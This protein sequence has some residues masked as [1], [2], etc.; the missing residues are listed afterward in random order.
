MSVDP[1]EPPVL[2]ALRIALESDHSAYASRPSQLRSRLNRILG[3]EATTH[4]REVHLVVTALDENVP[5]ELRAAAPLSRADLD[6]HSE[7]LAAA[8]GWT[9][10]A[11]A[12]AVG[13]WVSALGLA[14]SDADSWA[15]PAARRPGTAAA[16]SWR[17]SPS[18]SGSLEPGT[19]SPDDG[20]GRSLEGGQTAGTRDPEA[21]S[22]V[23]PRRRDDPMATDL[24]DAS[25]VV[26]SV[27]LPAPESGRRE[28]AP[29]PWPSSSRF[30]VVQ[31]MQREGFP[32]GAYYAFRG[33]DPRL[34]IVAIVAFTVVVT[35]LVFIPSAPVRTLLL[36]VA[37]LAVLVVPT[38]VVRNGTMVVDDLGFRWYAALPKTGPAELTAPWSAVRL[39]EG[40]QPRLTFPDGELWLKRRKGLLEAI[41]SRVV[42]ATDAATG[43]KS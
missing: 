10:E 31:A 21:A 43:V 8:R 40:K 26:A 22:T 20:F 4:R 11:G 23:L 37:V 35:G 12:A 14:R 13:L 5:T 38:K 7:A 39:V 17:S 18:S 36:L 2:A 15:Q 34:R 30:A 29:T 41:R 6:R 32:V 19:S 9:A 24:P 16:G 42:V 3:E 27:V 33:R 25:S 28:G 1:G